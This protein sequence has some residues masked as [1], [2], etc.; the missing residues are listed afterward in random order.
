[1]TEVSFHYISDKYINYLRSV[2]SRVLANKLEARPYVLL[3]VTINDKEY[4]IPLSSPKFIEHGEG[5]SKKLKEPKLYKKLYEI[6]TRENEDNEIE[7]LGTLLFNNMIP[8][9]LDEVIY[10][11][12]NEILTTQPDYGVLLT[13][14]FDFI[15]KNINIIQQKAEVVYRMSEH[16][17]GLDAPT[18]HIQKTIK[19]EC[20]NFKSLER[21]QVEFEQL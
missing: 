19:K 9:P 14:Q 1:M 16:I 21:A 12:F 3:G 8:A 18:T 11:E 10:I 6:M 17:N 5:G 20:C 2:D 4:Y 15:K 7:Y 13:K